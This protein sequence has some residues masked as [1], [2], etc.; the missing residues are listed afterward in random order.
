MDIKKARE[1]LG[2]ENKKYTDE[3]I[4]QFIDTAKFFTEI[5]I[6]KINEMKPKKMKSLTC[7]I[8]R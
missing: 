6:E 2:E 4:L 5:A 1:L 8:K 3:E 7:L